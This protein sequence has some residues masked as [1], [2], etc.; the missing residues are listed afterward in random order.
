MSLNKIK[1]S[2]G[3]PMVL[4]LKPTLEQTLYYLCT[5]KGFFY[6]DFEFLR[7]AGVNVNCLFEKGQTCL[8]LLAQYDIQED[9]DRNEICFA[10]TELVHIGAIS[11]KDEIG[12]YPFEYARDPEVKQLLSEINC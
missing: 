12:K 4:S 7:K 10:I 6:Y 9:L 1:A 2:L 11:C 3:N 5:T 8:H